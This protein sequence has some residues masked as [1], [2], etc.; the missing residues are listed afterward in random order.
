MTTENTK[1][2]K[3]SPEF[4]APRI[5]E[6]AVNA[7]VKIIT[8]RAAS[9]GHHPREVGLYRTETGYSIGWDAGPHNWA[10]SAASGGE[11]V[12]GNELDAT[13]PLP[14]VAARP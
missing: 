6:E 12:M 2:P 11:S 14:T 1:R 13:K 3:P 10:V 7:A 5:I 9:E 8:E 4:V